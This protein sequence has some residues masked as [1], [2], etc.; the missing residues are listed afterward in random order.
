MK[1]LGVTNEQFLQAC[2]R[3]DGNPI[4]KKIVDQIV[5]VDNFLAFKK[6][7]VKR[8]Q[9]LN[10]QAAELFEKMKQKQQAASTEGK[11]DEK[12]DTAA[13]DQT[14]PTTATGATNPTPNLSSDDAKKQAD[15]LKEVMKIAQQIEKAEEEELMKRALEESQKQAEDAKRALDDEEEMLR[16]AIEESQREEQMRLNQKKAEEDAENQKLQAAQQTSAQESELA[17]QRAELEERERK[18]REFEER[19]RQDTEAAKR[20]IEE[21]QKELEDKQAKFE[22]LQQE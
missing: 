7:M 12:A 20:M 10:K 19:Q 13:A 8:N 6:L 1:E 9:E 21:R 3:A 4:H 11:P 5:A 22:K 15:E 14:A 16:K 2:E 17:R 18:L